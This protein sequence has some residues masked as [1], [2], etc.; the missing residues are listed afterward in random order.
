[1]TDPVI[2][3]NGQTYERAYIQ[4]WLRLHATDP[5]TNTVINRRVLIPNF[6]L[7]GAIEAYNM[8]LSSI[9]MTEQSAEDREIALQTWIEEMQSALIRKGESV[10]NIQHSV[11][12]VE[13]SMRQMRLT[14]DNLS[15]RLTDC[16]SS[17]MNSIPEDLTRRIADLEG[18]R[19]AAKQAELVILKEKQDIVEYNELLEYYVAVQTE[20]NGILLAC[21]VISSKMVENDDKGVVGKAASV[22][23]FAGQHIASVPGASIAFSCVSMLLSAYDASNQRKRVDNVVTIFRN[24]AVLISQVTEI[25]ARELTKFYKD[26]LMGE[27]KGPAKKSS[28]T[29]LNRMKNVLKRCKAQAVVSASKKM[30]HEHVESIMKAIME[31][32]LSVRGLDA[33]RISVAIFSH[34]T[35]I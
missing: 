3:T 9:T 16:E 10:Q 26:E 15:D 8:Q 29:I 18:V 1:M 23:D 27:G 7:K 11:H 33:N 22:I 30:A 6:A 13:E 32:E 20:L 24:D 34:I 5:N 25:V 21:G 14:V 12:Q 17:L 35:N 2:T 19:D 4:E 31:G 28:A